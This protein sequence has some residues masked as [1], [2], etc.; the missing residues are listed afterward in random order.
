MLPAIRQLVELYV[1]YRIFQ[2][3]CLGLAIVAI[4]TIPTWLLVDITVT[5]ICIGVL[6]IPVAVV[7]AFCT[8]LRG[9]RNS[10]Y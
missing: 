10:R 5:M 1:A 6:M 8:L 7:W 3:L 9:L 4:L 2:A